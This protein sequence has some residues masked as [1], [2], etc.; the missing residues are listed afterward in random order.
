MYM[1]F[2][3]CTRYHNVHRGRSASGTV[4]GFVFVSQSTFNNSFIRLKIDYSDSVLS[5][6]RSFGHVICILIL[7]V[8]CI[9][10]SCIEI[11]IQFNFYFHTSLRCLKRFYEGLHKTFEAPQRSVKI[12]I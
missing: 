2:F 6:I 11:K 3:S 4:F 1:H 12:E 9:S 5:N 7:P 10:E 8:P